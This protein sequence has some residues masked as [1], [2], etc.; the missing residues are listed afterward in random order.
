MLSTN[1]FMFGWEMTGCKITRSVDVQD[2]NAPA[3]MISTLKTIYEDYQSSRIVDITNSKTNVD[4]NGKQRNEQY[5]LYLDRSYVGSIY[6]GDTVEW[7]RSEMGMNLI[8]IN[9]S[10]PDRM[11]GKIHRIVSPQNGSSIGTLECYINTNN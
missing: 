9:N 11:V 8:Y 2:P 10:N 4:E 1:Y 7:N 5:L 3:D 6:E